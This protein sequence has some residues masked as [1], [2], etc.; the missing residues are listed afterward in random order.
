M[1]GVIGETVAVPCNCT[2]AY[3]HLADKPALILWY[4]DRSKLPI[5]RWAGYQ[6]IQTFI[7]PC[8]LL[9]IKS[10]LRVVGEIIDMTQYQYSRAQQLIPDHNVTIR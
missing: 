10:I 4:K 6:D 8:H 1:V 9:Q 7:F 5:Y 2:P 3:S